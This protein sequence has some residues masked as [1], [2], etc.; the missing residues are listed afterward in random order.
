V[1]KPKTRYFLP[2]LPTL[3]N[4]R[5]TPRDTKRYKPSCVYS[6]SYNRDT[7]CSNNCTPS[8]CQAPMNAKNPS[9]E[10]TGSG[11]AAIRA[12][13]SKRDTKQRGT[14]QTSTKRLAPPTQPQA[15]G[16]NPGSASNRRLT[17]PSICAPPENEPVLQKACLHAAGNNRKRLLQANH[18][19]SSG[20]F[21]LACSRG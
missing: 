6:I 5:F 13:R 8:P 21:Q 16:L 4:Q 20:H 15:P 19:S 18:A 3:A 17:S 10:A 11:L 12:S 9:V 7:Q 2:A 1:P 14:R